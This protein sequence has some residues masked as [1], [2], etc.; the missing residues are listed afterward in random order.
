MQQAA[1]AG[2]QRERVQIKRRGGGG[3]GGK[4]L[5]HRLAREAVDF[6]RA[7]YALAVVGL[8]RAAVSGSS[9]CNS[10]YKKAQSVRGFGRLQLGADGGAGFGQR[11]LSLA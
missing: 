11:V 4:V 1:V 10:L 3:M 6:Q 5:A 8:R 2:N 9:R 7:F